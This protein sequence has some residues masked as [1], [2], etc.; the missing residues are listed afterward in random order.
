MQ[1]WGGLLSAVDGNQSIYEQMSGSEDF[2][3]LRRRLRWFVFPTSA[4]FLVWYLA[5][6]LLAAYAPEFMAIRLAGNF[7]VG[8]L[9][10]LLQFL[11]TFVI[12][13]VYVRYANRSLDPIATQLREEIEDTTRRLEGPRDTFGGEIGR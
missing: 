6:V 9:V 11:S 13:T 10:G 1:P 4:L 3:V 8:L 12:A 2:A 7:N 5:Y